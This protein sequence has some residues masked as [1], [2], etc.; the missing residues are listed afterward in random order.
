MDGM[1][2]R[3]PNPSDPAGPTPSH[4]GY[5]AP[6][7]SHPGY[8]A[9]TPTRPNPTDPQAWPA[10]RSLVQ[11]SAVAVMAA[12]LATG[13]TYLVVRGS[14]TSTAAT[15][16]SGFGESGS[17]SSP[18]ATATGSRGGT[19]STGPQNVGSATAP[20]LA[21]YDWTSVAA[22]VAPSVVSIQVETA[23]GGGQGSGVIIDSS[24]HILTNNHVA[25]AGPGTASISVTLSD[26]RT[27]EATVTGT[28]PSTDLAVLALT[29]QPADL[30]PIAFAD[31]EA[32]V[33]GQPV[34]AIGN[35]LG[36]AGTVTTGIISALNRPVTTGGESDALGGTVSEPVVTNAVQTSAA[37]N[38]GNSGG[39][40]VDTAGRLVG[41][42][43]SIAT[44]GSSQ[45]GSGNIG[46]GFAIPSNEAK[47][48]A[49]QLI[50]TGAAQHAYLGV[51]TRETV[52]TDG[53]DRRN[54]ALIGSVVSGSAADK[55]GLKAGDAVIAING[56][57]VGSQLAL[58]A[59][60]RERQ[61]GEAVTLTVLRNGAHQDIAVTLGTKP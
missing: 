41:I 3:A 19:G 44:L 7:P 31:S 22:A 29:K 60:I 57:P 51:Q 1:S 52:A 42:N 27:Y 32:L 58:V 15:G 38:P 46:I 10:R 54:A 34:M 24:G 37:I 13:G 53:R 45:G 12:A 18:A 36:L 26:G 23:S 49:G 56:E 21:S 30:T 5:A 50:T 17:S 14:T 59:A 16:I 11:L 55:A 47:A 39:A 40:L 25:T 2:D 20:Q 43:S 28:D 8:S 33:V 4:P 61:P 6:T 9:P 35:P 48:V